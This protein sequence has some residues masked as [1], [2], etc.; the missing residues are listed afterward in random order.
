MADPYATELSVYVRLDRVGTDCAQSDIQDLVDFEYRGRFPGT[1]TGANRLL[2]VTDVRVVDGYAK[3]RV[4]V[5]A[6]APQFPAGYFD[7]RLR[8]ETTVNGVGEAACGTF[9][10]D[11]IAVD[12]TFPKGWKP[13]WCDDVPD[14]HVID[15]TPYGCWPDKPCTG[16]CV[17]GRS[18]WT[19]VNKYGSCAAARVA[20]PAP[21]D[22]D[23][24]AICGRTWLSILKQS[25]KY[26]TWTALAQQYVAARLNRYAGAC[27]PAPVEEAL[28]ESIALLETNCKT[29]QLC[30]LDEERGW[31]LARI[32]EAYNLGLA[33]P[34]RCAVTVPICP[35]APPPPPPCDPPKGGGKPKDDCDKGR[36]K[37]DDRKDRSKDA[38]DK[39][40]SKD[41]GRGKDRPPAACEKEPSKGGGDGGSETSKRRPKH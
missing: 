8:I 31:R 30:G 17:K 32:L 9:D 27:G 2:R 29:R 34:A 10:L 37:A 33:G 36:S 16:G 41:G 11:T 28:R 3:V 14:F 23:R 35:C 26:D 19:T 12:G 20:W 18:W 39:G 7:G 13:L 40:A 5:T 6:T 38:D 22:E 4:V 24:S 1:Q 15:T 21:A 25:A